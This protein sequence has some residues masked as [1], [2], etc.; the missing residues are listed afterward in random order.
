MEKKHLNVNRRKRDIFTNNFVG[1]I[2]WGLGI[3]VGL[4]VFL[5]ILAFIGS[6]ID[7]VPV[8]GD[9]AAKVINYIVLTGEQFPGK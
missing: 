5:A 3:T 7:L 8:V 4:S 1:G 6:R 9:F 2:A